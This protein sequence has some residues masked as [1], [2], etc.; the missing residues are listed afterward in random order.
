MAKDLEAILEKVTDERVHGRAFMAGAVPIVAH[1]KGLAPRG[2]TGRLL[3]SIGAQYSEKAKAMR[4]G[5]GEPVSTTPSST[6]YYGRFQN[7]GWRPAGGRRRMSGK[8][9]RRTKTSG[10]K[11]PGRHFLGQALDAQESNAY[12]RI[13][14]VLETELAKV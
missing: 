9:D 1:A 14:K 4:I 5:I 12:K 7:D 13:F 2:K 6:G 8:L 10:S 11:V 3:V